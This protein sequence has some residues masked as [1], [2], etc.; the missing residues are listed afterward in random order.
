MQCVAVQF[1]HHLFPLPGMPNLQI[2]AGLHPHIFKVVLCTQMA[3]IRGLP[4]H[5]SLNCINL[6]L[7]H[8]FPLWNF[9]LFDLFTYLSVSMKAGGISNHFF[10]FTISF[11]FFQ[12]LHTPASRSAYL[13]VIRKK[14]LLNKLVNTFL[15]VGICYFQIVYSNGINK[16]SG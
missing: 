3:L 7:Y 15:V 6:L 4:D 16:L 9:S 5:T 8:F 11:H 14:S 12:P 10:H 13:M 2:A 1:C